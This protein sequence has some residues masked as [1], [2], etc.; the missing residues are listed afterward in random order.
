MSNPLAGASGRAAA[1]RLIL[2]LPVIVSAA[3]MV[4]GLFIE[5]GVLPADGLAPL[6]GLF[7][8]GF[9]VLMMTVSGVMLNRL[10]DHFN[11][12]VYVL[13]GGGYTLIYVGLLYWLGWRFPFWQGLS[14]ELLGALLTLFLLLPLTEAINDEPAAPRAT[15]IA[16][17]EGQAAAHEQHARANPAEARYYQGIA[18]GLRE[19][20][21]ALQQVN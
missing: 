21:R 9:G 4:I 17:L 11:P 3:V 19:A 7:L 18:D 1:R 10:F 13:W 2:V 16:H 15:L 5:M 12:R 8:M 20:I 6:D 14:A